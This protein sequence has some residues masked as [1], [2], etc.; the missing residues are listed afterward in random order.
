MVKKISKISRFLDI[1]DEPITLPSPSIKEYENKPFVS[2]LEAIQSVASLFDG[3]EDY[4]DVALSNCQN[5]LDGLTQ[6]ESAAIHLYTIQMHTGPSLYQVLNQSLRA[7][8]RKELTPWF[9]YLRLFLTALEKLPS[10]EGNV[11]RGV[12][13]INISSKYTKG[14]QFHWRNVSSCT[15]D[16][17]LLKSKKY[18]DKRGPRTLFSI[19]CINGKSIRNHS[20]IGNEVLL[21]PDSYFEVISILNNVGGD[22]DIIQLKEI[23]S[24]TITLTSSPPVV[25]LWNSKSAILINRLTSLQKLVTNIF[26][27]IN[28][29]NS[30]S[31]SLLSTNEIV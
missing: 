22:L 6:D 11:W 4:V 27:K 26:S 1:P 19:Q 28:S 8:N 23:P 24:P 5:P 20:Y 2:L 31:S 17:K 13:E 14:M 25:G 29:S 12:R 9:P 15:T 18:L 30:N 16:L 21:M 10:L 7:E 3:I